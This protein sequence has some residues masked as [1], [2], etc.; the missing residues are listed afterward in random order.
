[1]LPYA[2]QWV[3][4]AALVLVY[5]TQSTTTTTVSLLDLLPKCA[6][7]CLEDFISTEYPRGA[8]SE[9]CDLNYLCTTETTSGYTLGEAGLRCSL[10]KCS[11]EVALSFDTYSICENVPGA[12]PR[13][14]PTIVA[15]ITSPANPTS[16]AGPTTVI[17]TGPETTDTPTTI[18]PLSTETANTSTSLTTS[19]SH[20]SS[21]E[22]TE[23]PKTETDKPTATTTG[24]SPSATPSEASNEPGQGSNLNSG[25]VIG[26]S[27]ASGIAGFFIIGVI[28]FFCCRKIR[29]KAQDRE[30][31][32][33]GGHMTEPP[34]FSFP[35]KR[36]PMGPRP[37][38]KKL[39]G[40]DSE[41]VRLV[42]PA[43]AEYHDPA[44]HP[45]VVVTQPEEDYEYGRMSTKN[46]DR[47]GFQSTSNLDFDAESTVSSRTVS[48]LL[49]DKP[50]LYPRPLRW[51]QQKKVRPSS[52]AN[53]FEE[54][55]AR[56][57]RPRRLPSPPL[58]QS[59]LAPG[60]ARGQN[61]H[62]MAGLPANPRAMMYGFE[63]PGLTPPWK[64]SKREKRPVNPSANEQAQPSRQAAVHG[65][66]LY[67]SGHNR[68][69]YDDDLDNYWKNSN[70]GFV[71][72]KVIQPQHQPQ[73][74]DPS[75]ARGAGANRNSVSDYPGYQFEFG[76]G[77]SSSSSESR[78][79]SRNSGGFRPLTPVR[80]IRTSL[81]EMQNPTGESS[82]H[83]KSSTARYIS[84]TK[85][86]GPGPRP[87]P[88][89]PGPPHPPQEIVSRPRI[90]RQDDIKRVQIRRGKP[91]PSPKDS[92]V[93]VPY[94]PD[95]FWFEPKDEPSS[96]SAYILPAPRSSPNYKKYTPKGQLGMPKKKPLPPERNLTPSRRG[97]DL[98]LQVE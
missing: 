65:T 85:S 69:D 35:P 26:V 52:G 79:A 71:G 15:T 60:N 80:E 75:T 33:I 16:T 6:S 13:T 89:P 47:A 77:D 49:P 22:S 2:S 68:V 46:A 74:Q 55:H 20:T 14:H 82:N 96:A 8:C 18:R 54:N 72:A 98:I 7:Q 32:E 92:E 10:S 48:D 76:F 62:L 37:S 3:L 67:P 28:I 91:L 23:H 45:A 1:M 9:G 61:R 59:G 97:E 24:S 66:S 29:R 36:P 88:G 25:A 50:T 83:G 41:S 4:T 27:V 5:L 40:T 39:F 34:D 21:S 87:L 53:V 17:A 70:A 30:F 63:G 84:T 11:M 44:Q 86:S 31:F 73:S 42:P 78:R 38:P 43:E 19:Q 56:P 95:D 64:G 81:R 51:S 93:T 94:S 12:L 57:A 58:Q 90:V